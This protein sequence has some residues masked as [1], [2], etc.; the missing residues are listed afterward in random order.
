MSALLQESNGWPGQ[1]F[2]WLQAR[3]VFSMQ[4]IGI[5][6]LSLSRRSRPRRQG[7]RGVGLSFGSFHIFKGGSRSTCIGSHIRRLRPA[8]T[9]HLKAA[10]KRREREGRFKQQ[11]IDARKLLIGFLRPL[12]VY[13]VVRRVGCDSTTAFLVPAPKVNYLSEGSRDG[14]ACAFVW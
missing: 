1:N 14:S 7:W 8:H 6:F 4:S 3:R 9:F 11:G 10:K 2:A 13:N 5:R 12:L